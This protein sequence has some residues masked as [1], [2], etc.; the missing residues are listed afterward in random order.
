VR[1]IGLVALG[2]WFSL[3]CA[4]T[5]A[6]RAATPEFALQPRG[7]SPEVSGA[8]GSEPRSESCDLR[9]VLSNLVGAGARDC[10]T[11]SV[12]SFLTCFE[13]ALSH[14]VGAYA[15]G[16]AGTTDG[17]PWQFAM[18]RGADR[19]WHVVASSTDEGGT[20][21]TE[22]PYDC[23]EATS[24]SNQGCRALGESELLCANPTS[25]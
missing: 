21:V 13:D 7:A 24:D 16:M 2:C 11:R 15:F 25:S 9:D 23:P 4:A 10:S 1:N 17:F 5:S 18:A 22:T 20:V 6:K 14:G 19:V 12:P 8:S 3:S